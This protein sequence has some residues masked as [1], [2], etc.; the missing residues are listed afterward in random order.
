MRNMKVQKA[1]LYVILVILVMGALSFTVFMKW[2]MPQES[3]TVTAVNVSDDADKIYAFN[4]LKIDGTNSFTA[5]IALTSTNK[6]AQAVYFN[7]S[8]KSV[9][10]NVSGGD[11]II[12][13]AG[14]SGSIEWKKGAFDTDYSVG[15]HCASVNLDGSFSLVKSDVPF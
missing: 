4:N 11:C 10:L 8:D 15:V 5:S 3:S 6:Y 9:E 13:P 14:Q 1:L 7:N 12:I 2:K